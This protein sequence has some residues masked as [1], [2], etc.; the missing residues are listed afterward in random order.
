MRLPEPAMFQKL[1]PSNKASMLSIFLHN[2]LDNEHNVLKRLKAK[3]D[4]YLKKPIF[5]D[6]SECLVLECNAK[7][8]RKKC[9]YVMESI[10]TI[11]DITREIV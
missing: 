10:A 4:F 9:G 11:N 6:E 5:K 8:E 1:K 3:E 7:S 2:T